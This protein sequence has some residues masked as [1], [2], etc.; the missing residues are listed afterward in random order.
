MANISFTTD[1]VEAYLQKL[2]TLHAL[3]PTI[4]YGAVRTFEGELIDKAK[5]RTPIVTGTLK[6]GFTG[7]SEASGASFMGW[8]PITV[9]GNV[10]SYNLEN[11]VPYASA[12]EYGRRTETGMLT[13][14]LML[15]TAE[16]EMQMNQDVVIGDYIDNKIKEIIE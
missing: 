8:Q 11:N 2:Q 14:H 1:E 4:F 12:V 16:A 15:R 6:R 3:T 5:E 10:Y 13:G 7:G 9:T